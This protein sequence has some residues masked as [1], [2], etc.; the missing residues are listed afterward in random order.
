ML[1]LVAGAVCYFA[2]TGVKNALG[3]DDA[4][5][6]FGI[7][8]VGG[9]IGAILTGVVA[10]PALGGMGAADFAIGAQVWK[11]FVAVAI[12]LVWTGIGSV[13]LFKLVDVIVGLRV[14]QEAE[15]EGLDLADH[16]ERSYNY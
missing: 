7:H 2:V 12:T 6:V 13:V 8:G 11:Q 1:G 4:L 9:F 15:R 16:G 14:T 3:Y 10:S 5:D